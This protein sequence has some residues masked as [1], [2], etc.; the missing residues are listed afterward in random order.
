M[1]QARAVIESYSDLTIFT[2]YKNL[3]N[4]IIIKELN[5]R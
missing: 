1:R 5:R 3:L 4:F 2:D